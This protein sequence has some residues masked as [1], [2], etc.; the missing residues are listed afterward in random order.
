VTLSATG[1]SKHDMI[2]RAKALAPAFR[3]RA[4]AA[5]QD[6]RISPESAAELIDA[7]FARMLVPRRLGGSELGIDAW[8]EVMLELGRADASHAWVAGLM[9]HIPQ[10]LLQLGE[11]AQQS[12]WGDG[13]DVP[14]AGSVMPLA[15]AVAV[16][17]GYRV[18][19]KGPFSSGVTHATWVFVGGFLPVDGPPTPA[20][21]V[22]SPDQ[23][24]IAD[25]WHT[26]GMRGTGSNTIVADDA[27]VPESHV[28]QI[29]DLRE[30]TGPGRTVN[31]DG[32]YRL[33]F[34]AYAPLGF[35]APILGAARGAYDDFLAYARDKRL[36]G[37]IRVAETQAMQTTLGRISGD[38]QAA[39]LLLRQVVDAAGDDIAT[40]MEHRRASMRNYARAAELIVDAIDNLVKLGSTSSFSESNPIQRAWR[41][42]RFAGSH[43]SLKPEI[44]Y[45]QFSR[46]DLL[47][48]TP[49]TL[50]I[51]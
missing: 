7:G 10:M 25:T 13:P 50:A 41:D 38:L 21:F 33:P 48:A 45:A 42:I 2:E 44:N 12:I 18:S 1:V 29:S 19:A 4:A 46:G 30:A 16:E 6:R 34:M 35:C 22:L 51:Y 26:I 24:E 32:I 5:E 14:T 31:P 8:F 17:G 3:E 11:E 23:Y 20:M 39:E 43:Q 40:T 36:P 28:L 27:F 37:G 49:P 9:A 15:K 47:V